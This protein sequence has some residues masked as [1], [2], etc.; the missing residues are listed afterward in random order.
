MKQVLTAVFLA[1]LSGLFLSHNALCDGVEP[2]DSMKIFHLG[3]VV[4]TAAADSADTPFRQNTISQV[5]LENQRR[6]DASHALDLLPGLSIS[7]V[8][9]RNE[10]MVYVRGFDLRQAPVFIDGIPEYVP[11]DGYVDLARFTTFDLSEIT[12]TKGFSS[13]L[14]GPNAM[15]G[16]I[17]LVSKKPAGQVSYDL[18]TSAMSGGGDFALN[19]GTNRGAYYLS[20]SGSKLSQNSYPLSDAFMPTATEDGGLRDN[21]Y[22]RDTKYN[23]RAGYT[24]N[25]TDEYSVTYI[26]QQGEKG[27]PVYAGDN[28]G[29]AIRYWQWP[30]WNKYS[31]YFISQTRL[32]DKSSTNS[33]T[34][35][36]RFYHD[37]FKNTV[38]AYDNAT[39]TTQAK[40]SSFQSYYDDDTWG[41]IVDAA[42]ALID[43][44]R[45]TVSAHWKHDIHRE[46]NLGEP[47]RA[48]RDATIS[49]GAEDA[50]RFAEQFSL[51]GGLSFDFRDELEAHDYNSKT[52]VMSNFPTE[53]THAVNAQVGGVFHPSAGR[54]ISFSIARKTRFSTMKDR[55]SFKLGTALPNPG[56]IPENAINYDLSY[57]ERVGSLGS[58]TV[59]GFYNDLRDVIQQIS[60]VHGGLS[61][62]QNLGHARYY[63]GEIDVQTRPT[64][65]ATAGANYTLLKREN[66]SNPDVKFPDTPEHKIMLYASY[67]PF[68]VFDV[69]ASM[70][71][72]SE[73]YSTSDG[74]YIAAPF[75]L[76]N[77][78]T[79]LNLPQGVTMDAG[80][81]NLFDRNYTL[82]EGYPEPGRMYYATMRLHD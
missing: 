40:K 26:S 73:R 46:H 11:Y 23:L 28:P 45:L 57:R 36:T 55:Y 61:Q 20:A 71:Y 58:Y 18:S 54:E 16:A 25:A 44:N 10:S 5:E 65:A 78:K 1:F 52:G 21:S 19:L 14:Y 22:R 24:P 27:T 50:Y 68:T 7:N 60:N 3:E 49:A 33:V 43:N 79:S 66:L 34:V 48:D 15:G 59:S 62:M 9:G 56:L 63:G 76:Y 51:I 6:V 13:V 35:K 72:N 12:V 31:E 82:S 80:I 77:V 17:N 29:G 67:S 4:V 75:A 81:Q 8:G 37:K 38:F 42:A 74:V 69:A 53:N 47:V 41:A 70:E 64:D 30:D 2:P 39:Y 32:G